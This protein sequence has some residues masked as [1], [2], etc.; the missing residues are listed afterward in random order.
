MMTK[1]QRLHEV[2]ARVYERQRFTVDELAKEFG[3]SYRK[4]SSCTTP[5]IFTCVH[6][7]VFA[8]AIPP[9]HMLP[10]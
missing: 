3:V 9:V 5:S 4:K 7:S 2:I 8:I 10:A 1:T 6:M